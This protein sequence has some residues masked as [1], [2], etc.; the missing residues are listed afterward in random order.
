MNQ[1]PLE[2]VQVVIPSAKTPWGIPLLRLEFDANMDEAFEQVY[3]VD[4]DV[5]GDAEQVISAATDEVPTDIEVTT[6]GV[7]VSTAEPV[8]IASAPVTTAGV[9]RRGKAGKKKEEDANIAQ[10]DDVQAM[11]DADYELAARLQEQEQEELTI[12][13]KSRLF[14]ELIDKRKKHFAR[15]RAESARE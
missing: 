9:L 12:E 5:E 4:K 8:T 13:E 2:L 10:W 6:A 1:V 3:E 7:S 14:V 11:M 15:L